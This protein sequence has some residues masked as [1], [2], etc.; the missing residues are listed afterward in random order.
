MDLYIIYNKTKNKA[1]RLE[2]NQM[3]AIKFAREQA[4][5]NC[6]DEFSVSK[7]FLETKWCDL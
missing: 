7:T 2:T 4:K 3:R 1:I 6:G 5:E